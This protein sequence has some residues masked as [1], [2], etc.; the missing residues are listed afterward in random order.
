M[1]SILLFA[2]LMATALGTVGCSSSDPTPSANTVVDVAV[3]AGNFST[4]V[5]ALQAADLDAVL[6]GVGP[7][8]VF[9][10]TDA[11]FAQLPAGTVENLLLPENSAQLES[12]LTFHVLAGRVQLSDV[13]TTTSATTLNGAALPISLTIEGAAV[14][15]ADIGADNG[16]VH[17][18]DTVLLP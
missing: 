13:L 17:V 14:T 5:T 18:I 4:L 11:A 10:P 3:N 16:I 15:T 9:A 7:F 1:R 2:T 12:I 6:A 8:T